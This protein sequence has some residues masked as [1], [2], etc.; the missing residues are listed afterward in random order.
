M[1]MSYAKKIKTNPLTSHIPVILLTAKIGQQAKNEGLLSGADAYL[2]KPFDDQELDIRLEKLVESRRRLQAYYL[3]KT[4]MDNTTEAESDSDLP[5]TLVVNKHDRQFLEKVQDIIK[6]HLEDPQ[7]NISF[8]S[9]ETGLSHTQLHRKMVAL[10]GLPPVKFVRRVRLNEACRLLLESSRN[11]TEVAY[12]V[13]FSDP[14][15]FSKTFKSEIG[16]SPKEYRQ[17]KTA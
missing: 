10:V 9:K 13:G 11:I 3:Q 8:L 17:K 5:E 4:G 12:A 6:Q 14:A 15:Y 16:S 2:T 1:A 7:F